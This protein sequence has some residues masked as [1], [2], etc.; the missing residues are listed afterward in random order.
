[1]TISA[2]VILGVAV[3]AGV[4]A[5]IRYFVI[6]YVNGP[7]PTGTLLV[8]LTASFLLGLI[9]G[10]GQEWAAIAAIG[11][12]GA[13]STWSTAAN[14]AAV[15]AREEQGRLAVAYLALSV[16]AGVLSAWLGLT[17]ASI[18]GWR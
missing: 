17:L 16:M 3:A 6:G 9:S 1:M 4:G 2:T 8:N 14:E 15:M 18:S 10:L 12:L 13:L 5:A 7:F 11:G